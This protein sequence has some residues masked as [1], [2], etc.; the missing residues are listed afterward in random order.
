MP[1][2]FTERYVLTF[3]TVGLWCLNSVPRP[4]FRVYVFPLAVMLKP[5]FRI[6]HDLK[7]ARAGGHSS[8]NDNTDFSSAP[9]CELGHMIWD[10]FG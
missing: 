9:S 6:I 2:L 4:I 5:K 1:L 3:C 8:V 10:V 7:F